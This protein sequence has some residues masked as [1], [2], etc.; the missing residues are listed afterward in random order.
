MSVLQVKKPSHKRG[1]PEA[2]F[3]DIGYRKTECLPGRRGN[4]VLMSFEKAA[5]AACEASLAIGKRQRRQSLVPLG[6]G[7]AERERTRQALSLS[8]SPLY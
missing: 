2:A 7:P 8:G 5:N 1:G 6:G 4:P 3:Y